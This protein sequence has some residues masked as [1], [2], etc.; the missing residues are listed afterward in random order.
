[1]KKF[2]QRVFI[3]SILVLYGSP[4]AIHAAS[5][6]NPLA[7]DD[8]QDL[9]E[10]V[11]TAF[12]ILCIPFVVFFVIFAGFQYVTA[13]GSP[14]KIKSASRSLTYA[15]IGGVIIAGAIAIATIVGSTVRS[16]G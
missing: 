16:F 2:L 3:S 15:I 11:L 4:I 8:I 10:A 9:F 7:I 14:E 6:D 13:Q 1:M 5:L 12:I